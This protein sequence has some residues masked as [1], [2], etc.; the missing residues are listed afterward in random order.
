MRG[1]C[2]I[3]DEE[4]LPAFVRRP[5][6]VVR[7]H[8]GRCD[9]NRR[10]RIRLEC[11]ISRYRRIVDLG[12]R[13]TYGSRYRMAV[14]VTHAIGER[15]WSIVVRAGCIGDSGAAVYGN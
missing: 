15:V 12:Y 7:G 5:R 13:D 2:Q 3:D 10:V 11:I 6:R 4:W 1:L 9:G 14:V 8:L